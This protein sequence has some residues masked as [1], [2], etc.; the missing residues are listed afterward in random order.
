VRL[1]WADGVFGF[2]VIF[3]RGD[4]LRKCQIFHWGIVLLEKRGGRRD[5]RTELLEGEQVSGV[6]RVLELFFEVGGGREG[7]EMEVGVSEEK[8]E[9]ASKPL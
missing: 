1:R 8:R 9:K 5:R 3:C 2:V 6:L 7:G 4:I